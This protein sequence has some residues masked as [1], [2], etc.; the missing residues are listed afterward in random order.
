MDRHDWDSQFG[1][2][3]IAILEGELSTLRLRLEARGLDPIRA[4]GIRG[5]IARIKWVIALKEPIAE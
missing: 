5:E 3:L 1:R 4:E 2:E